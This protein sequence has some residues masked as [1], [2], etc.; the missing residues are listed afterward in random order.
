M[1]AAAELVSCWTSQTQAPLLPGLTQRG[2]TEWFLLSLPFSSLEQRAVALSQPQ[3]SLQ[4]GSWLL[5][6]MLVEHSSVYGRL[7]FP[8][9]LNLA[10]LLF[11]PQFSV[12]NSSRCDLI[13][14]SCFF[15][16]LLECSALEQGED[17]ERQ[18]HYE[19]MRC[20]VF[21]IIISSES[22]RLE[23]HICEVGSNR[24]NFLPSSHTSV[25]NLI[26]AAWTPTFQ[27]QHQ[28]SWG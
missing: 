4:E 18:K 12:L 22:A 7:L 21:F 15:K 23:K 24:E 9:T 13:P 17:Q 6:G 19:V 3:G 1:A 27:S 5:E 8:Y 25:R 11:L 10:S 26:C 20:F 14:T 16:M 2:G 28:S